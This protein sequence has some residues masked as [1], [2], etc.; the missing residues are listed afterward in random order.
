MRD[1]RGMTVLRARMTSFL[2][3]LEHWNLLANIHQKSGRKGATGEDIPK[4]YS[5]SLSVSSEST[6]PTLKVLRITS[7]EFTAIILRLIRSIIFAMLEDELSALLRASDQ[8]FGHET[9]QNVIQ[10]Q[11]TH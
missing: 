4:S 3:L 2:Q 11:D 5:R 9:D 1:C 6:N 8:N 7:K 10:N